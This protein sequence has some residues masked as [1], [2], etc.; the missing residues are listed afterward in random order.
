MFS[1]LARGRRCQW[2][3]A[4]ERVCIVIRD[5]GRV[6]SSAKSCR[7]WKYPENGNGLCWAS[8]GP[9]DEEEIELFF[10]SVEQTTAVSSA[11]QMALINKKRI[12]KCWTALMLAVLVLM[13]GEWTEFRPES[14]KNTE[15]KSILFWNGA[16]RS[17]MIIF[18]TG[19]D[20][21]VQQ[22][23]PVS[24]CE[25]ISSPYQ[26]P[27]R[28][29]DSYDAIIFNFND[30]F[31]LKRRPK[32]QRRTDQIFVFFTQEPPPSIE[33]MNISDYDNYFNMT[34]TYRMDSDVRLL[35]GR[36]Q[37]ANTIAQPRRKKKRTK[38]KAYVAAMISHCRTDGRREEYIKRLKKH[39]KVDVYGY[40][41]AEGPSQL[42]CE[43]DELLSSVPE[44]YD[45]LE[46]NYKFYLSFENSICPD[47][48]TEKFFHIMARDIVPVVY[49]GA[50][51]AAIAPAHSYIDALDYEPKE[52]AQLLR[53]LA[54]N[55]TLYDEYFSWKKNYVVET[56]LT[57]MVRH[58]FCDL[59]RILHQR[60]GQ[61]KTF[62]SL[63]NRWDPSLCRVPKFARED[64]Q[65][66]HKRRDNN[67]T[68]SSNV[69][70]YLFHRHL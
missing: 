44:C 49:G 23:C 33:S 34:M 70:D 6:F 3:R 1:L 58:G 7:N 25:I 31:W 20:A 65:Q 19:H 57:Q 16:K 63:M 14:S 32:F 43:T 5:K 54:A 28:P 64:G 42:H 10:T 48:V 39:V 53:R 68:S 36:I 50:D 51:Y 13:Y 67:K 46:S 59:C 40:C 22:G 52:L 9:S 45:M 60:D 56:G 29:L 66:P 8:A 61:S 37:P 4:A 17:E 11:V 24:D 47:Y 27:D 62:S 21:F 41:N 26:F 38:R 30:E 12:L 15:I 18:G 2:P 55:E 35:Y 69:M